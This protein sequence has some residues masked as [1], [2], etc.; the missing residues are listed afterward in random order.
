M[1]TIHLMI[2]LRIDDD[3]FDNTANKDIKIVADNFLGGIKTEQEEIMSEL[4]P[5]VVTSGN[6][7]LNP[8]RLKRINHLESAAAQ[9]KRK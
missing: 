7:G 4:P 1:M 9:I 8:Y 5:P 2:L 3:L 6:I